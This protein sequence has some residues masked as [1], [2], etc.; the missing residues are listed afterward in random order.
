MPTTVDTETAQ[1]T[2]NIIEKAIRD[3]SWQTAAVLVCLL[4]RR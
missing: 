2:L 1:E 4:V 3:F